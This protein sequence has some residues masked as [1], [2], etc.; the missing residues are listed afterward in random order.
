[1]PVRLPLLCVK[2]LQT[3][4]L[5]LVDLGIPTF[6]AYPIGFD[7]IHS[8]TK[9]A[10]WKELRRQVLE[11]VRNLF[12]GNQRVIAMTGRAGGFS[13]QMSVLDSDLTL[14]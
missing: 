7:G 13:C 6:S 5:N 8:D 11:A 10:S 14:P 9:I 3:R 4:Q 2:K 1:M 12:P